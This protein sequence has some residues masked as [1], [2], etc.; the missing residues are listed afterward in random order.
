MLSKG[1]EC[2]KMCFV[3]NLKKIIFKRTCYGCVPHFIKDRGGL[4]IDLYLWVILKG[5]F[6]YTIYMGRFDKADFSKSCMIT[7]S[8]MQMCVR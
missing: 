2:F 3:L 7:T 4:L 8:L 6:L 5:L 1:S